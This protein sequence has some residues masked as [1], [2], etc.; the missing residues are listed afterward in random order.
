[1]K[2]RFPENFKWGVSTASYQI[3]GGA[4]E[5]GRG[6]T[7]WDR[8][9]DVP[10]NIEDG[11][12]G[13]IACDHY[14]RWREDVQLMKQMGIQVYRFSIAWSRVY[15]EGCGAVNEEG[16]KFYSD[17]VDELLANGIEPCITLYHWD[18]P[19]ALQDRGG[20]ANRDSAQWFA[21]YCRT[22]FERLGGRVKMWITLNEPWVSCFEGL[23][24]GHF[25]PGHRDF[26]EA[27]LAVHNELR[28]HGMAVRI[29]REMKLP[30]EIGIVLSLSPKEPAT[31]SEADR[32]A[33]WRDDGNANRW[34]L[35]PVFK[36]GYPEDMKAFYRSKGIRLPKEHAGD[37]ELI[38]EPVDFLGVNNYYVEFAREDKSVWP[39]E[40]STVIPREEYRVTNYDWPV[41]PRGLRDLLVRLDREY[42]H[43]KLYITENG[44]SYLD[45]KNLDG[46]VIDD[47]R[48]D[49][50]RQHIMACHEAIEQGAN[51]CG[52][53]VWSLFD[54][55][56]WNTGF[57]NGFGLVYVDR[58]SRDRTI[59]K[60]GK[61]YRTVIERNGLE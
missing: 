41:I 60:S 45:V 34:F 55:F 32:L 12:T 19:Q 14:H 29:F 35:D 24:Y 52:Y 48:L 39:M 23:A 58:P 11:C 33:A 57:K 31:G 13:E 5:G 59:K 17:L 30:G 26:S 44:A 2:H 27:L 9:S 54:N 25:A 47:Q 51:L 42:D 6:E 20:W 28:G 50:I 36:G 18:L 61:W 49:Y 37:M 10:G 38:A 16:L 7:I 46:E 40:F 4:R 3:E 1:M 8:F 56:E 43:P 53:F 22:V 21:D 15:P